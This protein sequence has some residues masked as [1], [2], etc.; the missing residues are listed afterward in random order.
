LGPPPASTHPVRAVPLEIR[1]EGL[2]SVADQYARLHA[3]SPRE[4]T[5]FLKFVVERKSNKEI[6][7]ELLIGYPTVKLYWTRICRKIG[8]NNAVGALSLLLEHVVDQAARL[9]SLGRQ[10]H[11]DATSDD[12]LRRLPECADVRRQG[13]KE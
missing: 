5:V 2:T 10:R 13:H 8:A 4:T 6:A 7:S 9:S 12:D 3:L 11:A 1:N